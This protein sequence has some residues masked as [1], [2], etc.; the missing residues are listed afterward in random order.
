[1]NKIALGGSF[2]LVAIIVTLF[3]LLKAR[4]PFGKENSSFASEPKSEITKIEISDKESR[5]Y[6]E[7]DGDS[8][9]LNGEP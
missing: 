2:L 8:W 4:S 9:F 1:M 3:V 6:L 5:L 7:K